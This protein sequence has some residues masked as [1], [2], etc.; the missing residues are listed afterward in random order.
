MKATRPG[1]GLL[2]LCVHYIT[3]YEKLFIG[4]LKTKHRKWFRIENIAIF[5]KIKGGPFSLSAYAADPM[6]IG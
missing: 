5:T 2:F 6:S 3:A 4:D 1:K